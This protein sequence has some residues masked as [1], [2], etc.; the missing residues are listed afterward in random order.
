[1]IDGDPI[2]ATCP[3]CGRRL[4]LVRPAG[5][6]MLVHLWSGLAACVPG[7]QP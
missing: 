4:V 6:Q 7:G 2:P 1:M 3:S 5:G